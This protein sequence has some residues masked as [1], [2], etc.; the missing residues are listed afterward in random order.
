M[1]IVF[2]Y[3]GVEPQNIA[4]VIQELYEKYKDFKIKNNNQEV[5]HIEF[6]KINLYLT[7]RNSNDNNPIN[8]V[9]NRNE[10]ISWTIKNTP[11]KKTSKSLVLEDNENNIYIYEN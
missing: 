10:E 1:K 9:N 6:G 7:L 3:N 5:G 4:T 8:F 11:M 2:D